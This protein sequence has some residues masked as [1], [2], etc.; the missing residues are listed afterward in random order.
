MYTR[1]RNSEISYWKSERDAQMG[2]SAPSMAL[3]PLDMKRLKSYTTG[4]SSGPIWYWK[5]KQSSFNEYE[6][7]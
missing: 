6:L 3:V 7:S 5:G 4:V 1:S 2:S